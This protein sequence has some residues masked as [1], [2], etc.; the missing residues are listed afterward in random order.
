VV[1][2]DLE[3]LRFTIEKKGFFSV[4]LVSGV[5]PDYFKSPEVGRI[6]CEVYGGKSLANNMD[7]LVF[8]K[9]TPA[10]L[11]STDVHGNLL[12]TRERKKGNPRTDQCQQRSLLQMDS[13]EIKHSG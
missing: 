6:L 4:Y 5:R 1:L 13:T 12:L 8:G 11:L 3:R 7:I 2:A 9:P 10:K